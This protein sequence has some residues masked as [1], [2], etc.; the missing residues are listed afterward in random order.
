MYIPQQQKLNW[1]YYN[2]NHMIWIQWLNFIKSPAI[3]FLIKYLS[4]KNLKQLGWQMFVL[5]CLLNLSSSLDQ[6]HSLSAIFLPCWVNLV[7]YK[8]DGGSSKIHYKDRVKKRTR[9]SHNRIQESKWMQFS[10][11]QTTGY[12][13]W[14][15]TQMSRALDGLMFNLYLLLIHI[16]VSLNSHIYF[17]NYYTRIWRIAIFLRLCYKVIN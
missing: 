11:I 17:R 7:N 4:L 1:L 3:S 2:S 6:V 8:G 12:F 13:A 15:S 9:V 16:Q 10:L 14:S 5:A